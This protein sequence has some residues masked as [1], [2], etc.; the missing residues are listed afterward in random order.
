MNPENKIIEIQN[1][2]VSKHPAELIL[3]GVKEKLMAFEREHQQLVHQLQNQAKAIE[4]LRH[5]VQKQ[6]QEKKI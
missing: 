4:C 5:Q 1:P 3:A 6:S 2:P